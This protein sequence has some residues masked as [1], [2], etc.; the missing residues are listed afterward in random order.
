M[1]EGSLPTLEEYLGSASDR[2]TTLKQH[3]HPSPAGAFLGGPESLFGPRQG[4]PRT[5]A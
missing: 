3:L 2:M 5:T 4:R 1:A